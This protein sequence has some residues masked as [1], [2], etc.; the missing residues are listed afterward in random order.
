[1]AGG[2]IVSL[3]AEGSGDQQNNEVPAVG[4]VAAGGRYDELVGMFDTKGK[5][6]PCVGLSIGIERIFSILEARAKVDKVHRVRTIETQVLVASGQKNMLEE[7]MKVCTKLWN[8]GIKVK[9]WMHTPGICC[10][11]FIRGFTRPNT[12]F[13]LFFLQCET[14][15]RK[16]PKMLN[17]FQYCEKEDIPFIVVLGEGEMATGGVTLRDVTSR[18]E[19]CK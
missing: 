12:K 9:K 4:S 17:Q 8:A 3:C 19:V 15:Y 5:P 2:S 16:N 13:P 18:E 1:M 10:R 7:R 6:V 14:M 11:L